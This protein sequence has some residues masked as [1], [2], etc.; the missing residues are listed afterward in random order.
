MCVMPITIV[1]GKQLDTLDAAQLA[2]VL[3][4]YAGRVSVD[5]G[6]GDGAFAYR[7]A[8]AHLERFVIAMPL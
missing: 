4:P 3:A 6:A 7:H 5:L 1:R 2:A 8:S